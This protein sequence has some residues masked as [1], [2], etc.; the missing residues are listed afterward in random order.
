MACFE[1]VERPEGILVYELHHRIQLFGPVFQRCSRE[2]YAVVGVDASGGARYLSVPVLEALHLVHDEEV[3]GQQAKGLYVVGE[4]V[5][6]YYLIECGLGVQLSPCARR[7]FHNSY[8]RFGETFYF[9]L[10]LVFERSGAHYHDRAYYI[11]EF[12]EFGGS[13]GLYGLAESHFVGE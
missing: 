1:L 3:G 9:F 12:H 6:R 7:S 8:R 4:R 5:V 10:P 13:E 11:A 2:D